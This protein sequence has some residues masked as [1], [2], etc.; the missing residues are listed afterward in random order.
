MCGRP[1]RGLEKSGGRGGRCGGRVAR[2]HGPTRHTGSQPPDLRNSAV[3]LYILPA[4]IS[5]KYNPKIRIGVESQIIF[6][7][8]I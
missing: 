3:S 7:M 6:G 5:F 4:N 8:F 1:R 2:D